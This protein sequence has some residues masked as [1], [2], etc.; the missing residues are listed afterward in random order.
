MPEIT[1][2]Q[3]AA[4]L[5]SLADLYEAHPGMAVP[6]AVNLFLFDTSRERFAETVKALGACRKNPP[7]TPDSTF[8]TIE[9]DLG[10]VPVKF[11]TDRSTICRKVRRMEM[12]DA[13]D[14]SDPILEGLGK[15]GAE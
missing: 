5:R 2:T 15:E 10:G 7:V 4:A 1:P 14:C 8:F 3:F 6:N 11:T 9:K 12:V 13:W